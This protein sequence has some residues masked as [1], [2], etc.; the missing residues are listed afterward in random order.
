[1][2]SRNTD[3]AGASRTREFF[4]FRGI[5]GLVCKGRD[6]LEVHTILVSPKLQSLQHRQMER[7]LLL[8][9]GEDCATFAF[10]PAAFCLD[11]HEYYRGMHL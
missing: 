3:N 2:R 8:V 11:M 4:S 10:F 1:M 9:A 6:R 5:S 7:A